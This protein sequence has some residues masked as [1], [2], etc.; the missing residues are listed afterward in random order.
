MIKR[1]KFD[2]R[3][4]TMVYSVYREKG[5]EIQ[6]RSEHKSGNRIASLSIQLLKDFSKKNRGK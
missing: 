5:R 1:G 4:K 2:L 3:V 6:N